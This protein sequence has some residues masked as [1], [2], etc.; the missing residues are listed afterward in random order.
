MT[1]ELES[2][3]RF[4]FENFWIIFQNLMFFMYKNE[5]M[6]NILENWKILDLGVIKN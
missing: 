3:V 2:L 5:G 1:I 6:I 4:C